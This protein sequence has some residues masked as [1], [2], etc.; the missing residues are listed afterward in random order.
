MN[1]VISLI[2]VFSM[3]LSAVIVI[4][5]SVSAAT[6]VQYHIYR[7]TDGQTVAHNLTS[8]AID[9][10]GTSSSIVIQ[11]A[12]EA[13]LH[14]TVLIENG[15]YT[16]TGRINLVSTSLIGVGN[17]THLRATSAVLD[18]IIM[19][20][21]N[22]VSV[23]YL[24]IST[25]MSTFGNGAVRRGIN[26][27]GATNS[28]VEHCYIHDIK[29][30]QGVYMS[31]G[32][33]NYVNNTQ[34]YNIGTTISANYGSGIAFGEQN[35]GV[36]KISSCFMYINDCIISGASMSSIDLEPANNI[37]IDGCSFYNATTWNGAETPVITIYEKPGW[38]ACD[39][40]TVVNSYV[41]GA[42][43]EFFYG[44]T[45][46]S[47]VGWNRVIYTADIHTAIYTLNSHETSFVNNTI[48]SQ[49]ASG[50]GMV[51]C[52]NMQVEYNRIFEMVPYRYA[53]GIYGFASSGTSINNYFHA[54]VVV[55][56]NIGIA[57]KWGASN[58]VIM[59]NIIVNCT[60]EIDATGTGNS[61]INNANDV[62]PA[63]SVIIVPIYPIDPV[64]NGTDTV[65]PDH[66]I[67]DGKKSVI[68]Q[69]IFMLI[70]VV[71]I[72]FTLCG[73]RVKGGISFDISTAL[74]GA[75]TV[76]MI[77]FTMGI[78]PVWIV[79][80]PVLITAAMFIA[81]YRSD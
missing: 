66:G 50:I 63:E 70:M 53:I 43:G 22:A 29:A 65:I 3:L 16:L 62:I 42:F 12:V 32:Q 77:G 44:K 80:F 74:I 36:S 18:S 28:E 13:S 24:Q 10:I 51:D 37:Y 6:A 68:T 33:Y 19:I 15:T 39:Q 64:N 9:F 47:V 81:Y 58:A 52:N 1:R 79:I 20:T 76:L 4:S 21:G 56:F 57:S 61:L 73:L 7:Q 78:W 25:D 71:M 59:D 46:H 27:L 17:A 38:P 2:L 14:K 54:N 55:G 48:M 67:Y 35:A 23:S 30:G 8:S 45:N 31:G 34:I 60:T 5:P 41:Y 11:Q 49:G 40:I 69:D 72:S 75:S 26:L